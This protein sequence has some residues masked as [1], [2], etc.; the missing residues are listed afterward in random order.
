MNVHDSLETITMKYFEKGHTFMSADSFHTQVERAARMMKNVYNFDDFVACINKSGIAVPMQASDFFD[1]KNL[2]S[3]G[4]DSDY[5]YV[6]QIT[7]AQFRKG[8]TKLFWKED[9]GSLTW[10]SGEFI[11]KSKRGLTRYL[12]VQSKG[13]P[14]GVTTTKA[15]DIR[16]KLSA[17]I[18]NTKMNFWLS[19]PT[20]DNS[21]DLTINYD[22]LERSDKK[23]SSKNVD[24]VTTRSAK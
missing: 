24:T 10:N 16:D 12:N 9:F 23:D 18:P 8:S 6:R 17:V 7:T 21:A 13:G 5:P 14:R 22:H 15:K 20:N 1:Y 19:L 2:L 3:H 11:Q 4:M